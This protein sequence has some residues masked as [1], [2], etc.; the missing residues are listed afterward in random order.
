MAWVVNAM[1]YI[2]KSENKTMKLKRTKFG[3]TLKKE[4]WWDKNGD[5]VLL[6]L[7]GLIAI[8]LGVMFAQTI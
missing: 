6:I 4:T 3:K 8:V 2:K 1:R 7:S 5:V